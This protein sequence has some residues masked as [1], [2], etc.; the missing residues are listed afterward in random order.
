MS[1]KKK[2]IFLISGILAGTIFFSVIRTVYYLH[3]GYQPNLSPYMFI[4]FS[5]IVGLLFSA[6]GLVI[7]LIVKKSMKMTYSSYK[8]AFVVGISYT[9]VQVLLIDKF[10]L[11]IFLIVNP[12]TSHIFFKSKR[13]YLS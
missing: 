11:F 8:E 6:I 7:E 5:P 9:T 13:K 2:Y 12:I 3:K 1:E 4:I 10:L